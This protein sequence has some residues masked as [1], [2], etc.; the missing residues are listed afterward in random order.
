VPLL[1]PLLPPRHPSLLMHANALTCPRHPHRAPASRFYSAKALRSKEVADVLK[2]SE[3]CSNDAFMLCSG[4]L[5][6]LL[7][8]AASKVREGST[9]R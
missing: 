5:E 8:S 1:V 9:Q 2:A 7:K 6:A 4:G 3:G